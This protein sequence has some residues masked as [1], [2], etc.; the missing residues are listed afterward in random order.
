MSIPVQS[1]GG[2]PIDG[3]VNDITVTIETE[4]ITGLKTFFFLYLI[5]N[6]ETNN[7]RIIRIPRIGSGSA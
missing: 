5:M 1:S 3:V 6:L 4:K 7:S 2:A